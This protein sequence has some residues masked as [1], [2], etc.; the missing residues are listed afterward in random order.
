MAR[1]KA[2]GRVVIPRHASFYLQLTCCGVSSCK[3]CAGIHYAHGPYWYATWREQ[4]SP[5]GRPI[6][7]RNAPGRPHRLDVEHT[8]SGSPGRQRTAYVGRELPEAWMHARVR[9]QADKR[10][11]LDGTSDDD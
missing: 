7:A 5:D 1:S 4:L 8:P 9:D 3:R 10:A 2:S 11:R 6:S